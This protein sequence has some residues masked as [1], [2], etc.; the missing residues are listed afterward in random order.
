MAERWLL[1]GFVG[2]GGAAERVALPQLPCRVGRDPSLPLTLPHHSISRSHAEFFERDGAL[3]LRDLGSTNGSYINRERLTG[4]G[5]L[6]HGD[7]IHL[8]SVELRLLCTEPDADD[9]EDSQTRF[10]ETPLSSRLAP[11][12]ASL[13]ELLSGQLLAACFQPIVDTRGGLFA[14]ELLGRG[15]HPLLPESP[16][17]LF[18]VA[19]SMPGKAAHLSSLM[20]RQGVSVAMAHCIEQPIFIN[21]HP[22][23]MET[24]D[25]V[26]ADVAALRAEFPAAQLVLEIHENAVT[27]LIQLKRF[28]DALA[29]TNVDLAYDDF[30]AGQ[31]RLQEM[32]EVPARYI[33]FDIA[34]IRGIHQAPLHRWRLLEA[35]VG[36]ARDMGV[37][38]LAE[39]IEEPGECEACRELGF[40]LLQGYL[41]ARPAAEPGYRN[42]LD[43]AQAAPRK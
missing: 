32:I 20:R 18:R 5:R 42:P 25:V 15:A 2:A 36:L 34:L 12:L 30:G 21:T 28:V 8:A 19:E 41:F 37:V 31:A 1:E 4:E 27:D 33:K 6:R 24:P 35:L 22:E 3:W 16:G 17:P 10:T 7:I 23:E 13:E 29:A 39:G 11:G 43:T 40:D 26:L 38:T 14:Y 9:E